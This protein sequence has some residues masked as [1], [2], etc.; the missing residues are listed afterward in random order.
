MPGASD[1]RVVI[2]FLIQF[3]AMFNAVVHAVQG[4]IQEGFGDITPF[5][6]NFFQFVR[7]FKKKIPEPP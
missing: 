1:Y 6:G 3:W 5:F 7:G 2:R 4:R